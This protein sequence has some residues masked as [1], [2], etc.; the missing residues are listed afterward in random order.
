MLFSIVIPAYN[1]STY[2]G[3][4]VSSVL[5]QGFVDYEIILV[6]DGANDGT[7]GLCDE[8]VEYGRVK[9]IHETNSGA[10][11]AR[12]TGMVAASGEYIVFLDSDDE[13]ADGYLEG[14]S[15]Q[16]EATCFDV[17]LG[18]VRTDFGEGVDERDVKL[19]DADYANTKDLKGLVRY[20]FT[21]A[22]DAPF[23][24]WHNVYSRRFLEREGLR[25]DEGLIWS[26][27][28]D[29]ILRVLRAA[30]SWRCV[31]VPGYRHRV[32]VKGSVTSVASADKILRAMDCDEK[33]LKT[34]RDNDLLSCA[35]PFL[36]GD[37][38]DLTMSALELPKG[39]ASEV[40]EHAKSLQALFA[41][42]VGGLVYG[43]LL[44]HD[45]P[46]CLLRVVGKIVAKLTR[47]YRKRC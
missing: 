22:D 37:L 8:L 31:A 9:V 45:A 11:H 43:W 44:R 25:F 28:R 10:S 30:P 41:P 47:L 14:L 32:E 19:F 7:A 3:G 12:N 1:C 23:A 40:M 17:L 26:E 20:F 38:I 4:C 21:S 35:Q 36:A 15:R 5:S 16:L 18:S 24:A 33:W 2:L 39:E 29:F 13:F 34:S 27:D 46:P 42:A 6:D